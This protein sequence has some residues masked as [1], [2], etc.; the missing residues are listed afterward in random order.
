MPKRVGLCSE[1]QCILGEGQDVLPVPSLSLSLSFSV[2]LLPLIPPCS[3]DVEC[4][5][6]FCTRKSNAHLHDERATALASVGF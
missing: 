3:L 5:R 2:C 6:L 1:P 4:V